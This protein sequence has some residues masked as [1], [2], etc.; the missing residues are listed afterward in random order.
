MCKQQRKYRHARIVRLSPNTDVACALPIRYPHVNMALAFA[1]RQ[2][3]SAVRPGGSDSRGASPGRVE[4]WICSVAGQRQVP[5]RPPGRGGAHDWQQ[6]PPV[7]NPAKAIQSGHRLGW[8]A[9]MLVRF[10]REP[11]G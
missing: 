8:R 10:P 4:A 6:P 9:L 2:V 5:D 3:G 1:Q 11:M 7:P